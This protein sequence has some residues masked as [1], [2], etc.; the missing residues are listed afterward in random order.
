MLASPHL[1]AYTAHCDVN[2]HLENM[3]R[4]PDS[5]YSISVDQILFDLAA[6]SPAS[7]M[8]RRRASAIEG[9]DCVYVTMD[10]AIPRLL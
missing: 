1:S 6:A 9:D 7:A 10:P 2:K 4:P 5:F 3:I 8:R